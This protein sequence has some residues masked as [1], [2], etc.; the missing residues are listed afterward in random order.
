MKFLD[1][2]TYEVVVTVAGHKSGVRAQHLNR[3]NKILRT[4]SEQYIY[5]F[6][7]VYEDEAPVF[8]V[9]S[10]PKSTSSSVVSPFTGA[11][12]CTFLGMS[13]NADDHAKVLPGPGEDI[14]S[15]NVSA[16]GAV[17]CTLLGMSSKSENY[18]GKEPV[19]GS[20]IRPKLI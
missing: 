7:I 2:S 12:V 19:P 8:E 17:V 16:P 20:N 11:V 15:N 13:R 4:V 14:D 3:N 18:T 6:D 9:D 1:S 5:P 10:M